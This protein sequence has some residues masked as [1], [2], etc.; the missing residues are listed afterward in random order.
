MSE[1]Q[2]IFGRWR[3]LRRHPAVQAAA[4]YVGGSWA[5]IQVADIFLPSVDIVRRLGIVLA[6]GFFAVVG[7]VWWLASRAAHD[8]GGAAESS[9]APGRAVR[10]R[11]R[12]LA[13]TAALGL[14]VLGGVFWWLRPNILGAVRPDAQV[15][16]VLPFNTSG[17]GVELLGEGMV[18]LLSPN[19]DAVGAIRTVDPRTVLHRWR[20]RAETGVLDFEGSLA[21]GRDVDAGA[22]LLGSVVSAGPEVRLSAELYTVQGDKL[23]DARTEGPA[24]SVLALVDSLGIALLREIWL[25]REPVPNLRVAAITTSDVEAI[26]AYLKGQQYYRRS[27]WDSALVAFQ[28]A[29]DADSTFA[30]AHYRLGLSYGWSTQ[31]GGFGSRDARLH[32][33]L[34]LRHADRLPEKERTLVTAHQLFEAGDLAAHDTMVGY[35]AR[36]GG[37]PE[38]WYLL[39]DVRVHAQQLLGL[40]KE[41]LFSPFD[42]VLQLD[43]SLAPAI[44]HPLELSLLYGDSS[45]YAGYLSTMEAAVEPEEAER[46]RTAMLFWDRP[47]S[48]FGSALSSD[49]QRLG[50]LG[51][52][53]MAASYNS[54]R[55][56]PNDL[57]D[58]FQQAIDHTLPSGSTRD[59][60]ELYRFGALM[61]AGLGRL[62]EAKPLFDSLWVIAE[63]SSAPYT[64]LLPVIAG[65]ADSSFAARAIEDAYYPPAYPELAQTFLYSRMLYALSQGRSDEARDVADQALAAEGEDWSRATLEPLIR[66]GL[67]WAD[68]IDGDTVGGL[69]KLEAGIEEAGFALYATNLG[70]PLRF[71]WTSTLAAYPPTREEG[72][73]RLRHGWS[74]FDFHYFAIR[75][76]LLGRALEDAGDALGAAEAYSQFLRLWERADPELQP[77]I[78]TAER[79]LERLAA[80]RAN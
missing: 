14:L 75:F 1:D 53:A 52:A 39:G 49:W 18:D 28:E 51:G 45:R 58:G 56:N 78:Q 60:I 66:A 63:N 23:A 67:G 33:E 36:H 17:P 10:R 31:H 24:D 73:R 9:D 68:I 79:A 21:V 26:R 44:I 32:A 35:V 57:M 27:Q 13:Y 71:V 46:F 65:I 41:D 40:D 42:R 50:S 15:I 70:G 38:G 5:L 77:R 64:S 37:D 61:L 3:E 74:F 54:K 34:A 62:D 55:V 20:Q 29:V 7:A 59:R 47:D 19:L 80:E 4:V 12:R 76:L 25:A 72:I 43:P 69:E 16:A 30:L 8:A 22:V 2:G 48:L 11:R 6:A